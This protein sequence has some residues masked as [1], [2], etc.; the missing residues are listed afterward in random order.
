MQQI[1]KN[2]AAVLC[3]YKSC[4]GAKISPMAEPASAAGP[5]E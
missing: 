1:A 3:I 4:A 5:I 2:Q